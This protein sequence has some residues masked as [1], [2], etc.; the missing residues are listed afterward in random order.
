[1]ESVKIEGMVLTPLKIIEG[2]LGQV[3]HAMKK[4]DAY[5]S[6]FGEAYFPSSIPVPSRRGGN[7]AKWL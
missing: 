4:T 3:M 6:G 7:T 1:M 2:E 5:F